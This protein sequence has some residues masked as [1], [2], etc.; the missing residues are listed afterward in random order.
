LTATGEKISLSRSRPAPAASTVSWPC[1]AG[2]LVPITGP[3]TNR[4]SV[5]AASFSI[6]SRPTVLHCHQI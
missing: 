1:S 3:S 5:P 2:P 6:Q 4:A